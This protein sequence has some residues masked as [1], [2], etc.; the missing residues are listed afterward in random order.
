MMRPRIVLLILLSISMLACGTTTVDVLP[1][2]ELRP[3][4]PPVA[5]DPNAAPRMS[6]PGTQSASSGPM[7]GGVFQLLPA[8]VTTG[9]Y[10]PAP[11]TAVARLRALNER[12]KSSPTLKAITTDLESSLSLIL[13]F[14]P[15][16][17][18]AWEANGFDVSRGLALGFV[19]DQRAAGGSLGAGEAPGGGATRTRDFVYAI[20]VQDPYKA[21]ATLRAAYVRGAQQRFAHITPQLTEIYPALQESDPALPSFDQIAQIS[22]RYS[23]DYQDIMG[24]S[25]AFF[26]QD[27][28]LQMLHKDFLLV[29]GEPF[30]FTSPE[31]YLTFSCGYAVITSDKTL[32]YA[33]VREPRAGMPV[34]FRTFLTA[35]DT[36]DQDSLYEFRRSRI[37]GDQIDLLSI[38]TL[39]DRTV[40]VRTLVHDPDDYGALLRGGSAT[41]AGGRPL[42]QG[43][44]GMAAAHLNIST[45]HAAALSRLVNLD[46]DAEDQ[47]QQRFLYFLLASWDGRLDVRVGG[48]LQNPRIDVALGITNKKAVKGLVELI[49][50]QGRTPPP[51]WRT[52]DTGVERTRL[53][54]T[55]G[56]RREKIDVGIGSDVLNLSWSQAHEDPMPHGRG[57]QTDARQAPAK[58]S[59]WASLNLASIRAGMP[60]LDSGLLRN[61]AI[62]LGG[63]QRY[64]V[65]FLASADSVS[66]E[67]TSQPDRHRV[68]IDALIQLPAQENR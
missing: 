14:D 8:A 56:R 51:Q 47:Y 65:W 19:E 55:F 7:C 53:S 44:S 66:L 59:N 34:R 32:A 16:R 43:D 2:R 41:G 6:P 68:E 3:M 49:A 33:G 36:V 28:F 62:S 18:E 4:K 48:Q 35:E 60:T 11:K 64:F 27:P 39:R 25:I 24:V 21:M 61:E 54:L 23:W 15:T 38:V 63:W 29:S 37:D 13:G 50:K 20:A 52:D 17:I 58:S 46:S 40:R 42:W 1:R 45:A 12:S 31:L 57:G 5:L 26:P 22:T 9:Y 67:L 10:L 30:T